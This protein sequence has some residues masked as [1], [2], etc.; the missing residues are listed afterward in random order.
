MESVHTR[1]HNFCI[2]LRIIAPFLLIR[3]TAYVFFLAFRFLTQNWLP[4]PLFNRYLPNTF[5]MA[6]TTTYLIV[7]SKTR[8]CLL[9][10][11]QMPGA[12]HT[13]C[14]LNHYSII[15][16][17]LAIQLSEPSKYRRGLRGLQE[18]RPMCQVLPAGARARA[19]C[20]GSRYR[21][22][23]TLPLEC[24]SCVGKGRRR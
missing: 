21:A 7:P 11:P 20:T 2:F 8:G 19:M 23:V 6:L 17:F 3:N 16:R 9:V 10:G 22:G 1:L 4:T 13:S 24:I 18:S 5:S 12:K 15:D 14:M